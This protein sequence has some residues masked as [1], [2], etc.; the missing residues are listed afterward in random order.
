MWHWGNHWW[1]WG[2][3]GFFWVLVIVGI[4][5]LIKWLSKTSQP[6]SIPGQETPLDIL[7]KRYARGEINKEEFERIKKDITS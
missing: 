5:V 2:G 3:M 4:I 1:M 6:G 7:K